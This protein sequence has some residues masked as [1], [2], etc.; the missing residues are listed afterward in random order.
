MIFLS[1]FLFQIQTYFTIKSQRLRIWLNEK[2]FSQKNKF[3][4][5]RSIKSQE[6]SHGLNVDTHLQT[7]SGL[8]RSVIKADFKY[9]FIAVY[10]LIRYSRILF[11]SCGKDFNW[12][13][14]NVRNILQWKLTVTKSMFNFTRRKW[15]AKN[16]ARIYSRQ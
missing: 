13:H 1:S 14:I 10:S 11:Y 12:T 4:I 9:E 6:S 16:Q 2:H 8:A 5:E 15:S 3:L 7:N